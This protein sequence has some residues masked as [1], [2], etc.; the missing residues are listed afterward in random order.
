M[1]LGI[2]MGGLFIFFVVIASIYAYRKRQN[3]KK[4][5]DKISAGGEISIVEEGEDINGTPRKAVP[6]SD[7]NKSYSKI[8][9]RS[10]DIGNASTKKNR[11]SMRFHHLSPH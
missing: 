6:R 10:V 3:S 1:Q 4:V 9:D 8:L 7:S 11:S 2:T 5:L